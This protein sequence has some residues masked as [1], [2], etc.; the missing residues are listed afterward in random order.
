MDLEESAVP[1]RAVESLWKW[2]FV[3]S[4]NEKALE[5]SRDI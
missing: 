2:I 5:T 3:V 4:T 1:S